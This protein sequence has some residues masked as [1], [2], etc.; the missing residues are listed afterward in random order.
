[1]AEAGGDDTISGAL[2]RMGLVGPGETLS[3]RPLTGGVSSDIHLA[4]AG[5]RQFC[6][7]RALPRL[8][9]AALWEAPLSRN[10]AEAAWFRAVGAWFPDRVPRILGE[11]PGIGLF[12]MTY[13]PGELYPVWRSELMEGGIDEGFAADVGRSL[14]AIHRRSAGDPKLR[15]AFANDPT[16][17]AI[18]LEPY[19]RATGRRHPDLAPILEELADR[20]LATKLALVHGDIS[21]KNILHG[22]DGPVFLDAECAWFGD[23]AFDLAFCLNHLLLK[24]SWRPDL[25][26]RY[27]SAYRGLSGAYLDGV[28][29]EPQG[30]IEARA[31]R[32]LPAL[33]LARIDG[34]SPVEY[35]PEEDRKDE[36]RR[37]SR[38]LLMR[39]M[40]HLDAIADFWERF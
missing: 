29:W 7:K 17:E 19:L 14:A 38:E 3:L 36:V 28:G 8:K 26:S 27:L 35:L 16:F 25:R 18:R 39:P 21:P 20:T 40:K 22:P 6:V 11:D 37:A 24:G 10:S 2:R 32:L 15:A 13:F 1:M 23:P 5:G 33:W 12:A 30:D 4:E 34:K 31:A 9:V